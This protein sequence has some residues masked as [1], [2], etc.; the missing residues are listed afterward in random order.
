L[1]EAFGKFFCNG[2]GAV[3]SSGAADADGEVGLAFRSVTG[4]EEGE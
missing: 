3:P 1:F 4:D 2:D